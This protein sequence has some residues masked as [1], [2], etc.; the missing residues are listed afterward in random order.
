MKKIISSR[1]NYILV[2]LIFNSALLMSQNIDI[3]NPEK[4]IGINNW[5]IVND[6]VMGGVSNSTLSLNE[7][8]NLVFNGNVSLDNNGGFASVRHGLKK[9]ILKGIKSFKILIKGD[10]NIYKLRFRQENRRAAYSSDFRSKAGKWIEIEIPLE[11]LTPS[12]RGYYYS[13]YPEIDLEKVVSLG[14]QIS[15]KQEGNFELEIKSIEG[16]Y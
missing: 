5:I 16:N 12:W 3:V 14:I 8:N 6:N 11:N 4:N 2:F 7:E 9:G 1:K 10:G 15:D 13:D